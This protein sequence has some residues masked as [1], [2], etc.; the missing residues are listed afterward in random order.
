MAKKQTK[1]FADDSE[2]EDD[3]DD[4]DVRR[5]MPGGVQDFSM[6]KAQ[7]NTIQYE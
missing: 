1:I 7:I 4:D 3:M 5:S 6:A 2:E